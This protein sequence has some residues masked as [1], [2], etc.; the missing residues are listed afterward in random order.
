MFTKDQLLGELAND[1]DFNI[2]NDLP[3]DIL[4]FYYILTKNY[5]GVSL[6]SEKMKLKHEPFNENTKASIEQHYFNAYNY[7]N[8]VLPRNMNKVSSENTLPRNKTNSCAPKQ[9]DPEEKSQTTS[10]I[11]NIITELS[12]IIGVPVNIENPTEVAEFM[13]PMSDLNIQNKIC[14]FELLSYLTCDERDL[15]KSAILLKMPYLAKKN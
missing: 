12:K 15:L 7:R 10:T 6:F 2:I 13:M 1:D 3:L 11:I 4:E 9:T 8:R 14:L 5:P